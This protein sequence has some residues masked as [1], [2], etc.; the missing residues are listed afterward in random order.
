MTDYPNRSLDEALGHAN[1]EIGRLRTQLK[2]LR[3]RCE[4]LIASARR[5]DALTVV[6]DGFDVDMLK[7]ELAALERDGAKV[8]GKEAA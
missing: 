2:F 3:Q 5:H 4:R 7:G 8:A 1:Q 6:V